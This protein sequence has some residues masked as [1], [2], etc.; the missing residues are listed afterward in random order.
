MN[1]KNKKTRARTK[2][3]K[4]TITAYERRTNY[5]NNYRSETYF[6]LQISNY[7]SLP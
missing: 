4:I 1:N 3:K 7:K 6:E 5:I 2:T